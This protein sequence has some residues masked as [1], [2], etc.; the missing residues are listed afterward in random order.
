MGAQAAVRQS[1]RAACGAGCAVRAARYG[2]VAVRAGCGVGGA[3]C[4]LVRGAGS[5]RAWSAG[6]AARRLPFELG[7]AARVSVARQVGVG[8]LVHE[9]VAAACE[10]VDVRGVAAVAEQHDFPAAPRRSVH[11]R[12]QDHVAVGQRERVVRPE[13]LDSF[14]QRARV[15][16]AILRAQA[17]RRTACVRAQLGAAPRVRCDQGTRHP[18]HL[19]S[20]SR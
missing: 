14:E 7:R 10:V 9:Q 18:L 11:L 19:S 17:L 4:G 8:G 20:T 15:L 5:A 16:D 12:A 13:L 6:V 3:G 2:W 1:V